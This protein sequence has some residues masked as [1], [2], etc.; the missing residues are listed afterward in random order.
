[1]EYITVSGAVNGTNGY[2]GNSI[3]VLGV[4]PSYLQLFRNGALQAESVVFTR[5]G[6]TITFITPYIPVSGDVLLASGEE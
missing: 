4:S 5:V 6:K 2:D 3:F 1:M